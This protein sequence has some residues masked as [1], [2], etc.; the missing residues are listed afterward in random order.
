MTGGHMISSVRADKTTWGEL[1]HKFEAGTAPMAEA[2]GLGAA[3]DY[4]EAIGLD[5]IARARA[6]AHGVRARQALR[7]PGHDAL[8]PAARTVAPGSSPSTSRGSIPTTSRRSSTCRASRSAPATTA[9]SRSCTSSAWRRRTARAS[10]CTRFPRRSTSSSKGST[11]SVRC[12]H[13]LRS[14]VSRGHPR[15]LQ[16]PARARG[17]RGS[18]TPRPTGRTRS[19]ATRSRSTSRS[20]TTARRS[21]R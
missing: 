13:E 14:D 3:I 12:L 19:A 15:P 21:T 6:R 16:E 20:A 7:D 2:V 5:K 8:R 18:P 11:P 17:H 10:T 4:L 1:P 9:A